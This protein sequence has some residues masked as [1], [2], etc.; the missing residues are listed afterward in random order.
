MKVDDIR[1]RLSGY[2]PG[3]S[4][5]ALTVDDYDDAG[6]LTLKPA[7]VLVGIVDQP[8]PHLLMTVRNARMTRHA[9][10]VAFPGGR[11]DPG[12]GPV[13][14]ALREAEEEVALPQSEVDVIAPLE[15]YRTGTGYLITPVVGVIPPGLSYRAHE[16]EVSEIFQIPLGHALDAAN[17][18][19][20]EAEWQGR[21]RRYF[22]IDW[23]PQHVWGATAGIIVNLS[24]TLAGLS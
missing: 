16:P 22:T 20:Q 6:A 18:I 3:T 8:E 4:G 24:R 1:R 14:T 5:A 19:E 12:E 11:S 9:G 13:E 7:A 23:Q 15:S 2:S 21:M 10:Q 17:H